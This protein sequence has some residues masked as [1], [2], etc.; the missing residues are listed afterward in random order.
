MRLRAG[1]PVYPVK[2]ALQADED[3][4]AVRALVDMALEA[5]SCA[6]G[7]VTVD[8]VREVARSPSVIASKA[9]AGQGANRLFHGS[10]SPN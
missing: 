1:H 10:L 7:Q 8:E 2:H 9:I 6:G 3:A 4:V 5:R